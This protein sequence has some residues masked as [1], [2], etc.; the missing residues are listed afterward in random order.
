MRT[1]GFCHAQRNRAERE[2]NASLVI[3]YFGSKEKLF[4]VAVTEA[5]DLGQAVAGVA[6]VHLGREIALLL[7]SDQRDDDLMAMI[8]RSALDQSVSPAV[9][10]LAHE[11]MLKSLEILIGGE[12][13]QHRA[14]TVLSLVTGLWFYRFALKLAPFEGAPTHGI[15]I[16]LPR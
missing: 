10:K 3:R 6:R 15:S 2:I 8:V 14:A 13:A 11:R 5:F 9:R 16:A 4:E 7:F 12:D 1:Q